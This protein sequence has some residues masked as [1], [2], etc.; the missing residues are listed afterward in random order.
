MKLHTDGTIE[1]TPEEVAAYKREMYPVLVT[2]GRIKPPDFPLP[3][4]N[5]R[6]SEV[7][8]A[9]S[10]STI[11]NETLARYTPTQLA[12]ELGRRAGVKDLRAFRNTNVAVTIKGDECTDYI[13]ADETKDFQYILIERH[14]PAN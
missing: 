4:V 9:A 3:G 11:A 12:S 1:G 7:T 6:P 13:T 14:N 8:H 10:Q 2:E 5:V